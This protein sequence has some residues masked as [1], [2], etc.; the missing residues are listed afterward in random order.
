MQDN[1]SQGKAAEYEQFLHTRLQTDL[2][3]ANL[4]R[5]T[6]TH[7]QEDYR[8]LQQNIELLLKVCGD[9]HPVMSK[10]TVQNQSST[11]MQDQLSNLKTLVPLGRGQG[12]QV[13]AEI[14]C[15]D[16]VFVKIGLGF[17]VQCTLKEAL[18]I[19]R[20]HEEQLHAKVSKQTDIISHIKARITLM[21]E[22]IDAMQVI[23]A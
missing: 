4:L 9:A 22:S 7:E 17:H 19:A 3:E 1:L 5:D 13:Q 12:V 23:Q 2:K 15:T 8:A 6:L 16:F 14:P 20:K 10:Q 21:Q 11:H 18:Q